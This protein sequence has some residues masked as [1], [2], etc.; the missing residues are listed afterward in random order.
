MYLAFLSEA[1]PY[2][3]AVQ[4]GPQPPMA[5]HILCDR[6][7]S[8]FR[9]LQLNMVIKASLFSVLLEGRTHFTVLDRTELLRGKIK[10]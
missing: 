8:L 10:R 5:R 2:S 6:D 1:K 9:K 3:Q 4:C 7:L